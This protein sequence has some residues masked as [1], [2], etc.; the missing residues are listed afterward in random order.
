MIEQRSG[1]RRRFSEHDCK[2]GCLASGSGA[3]RELAWAHKRQSSK[4]RTRAIAAGSD[5][6]WLPLRLRLF[7]LWQTCQ[8]IFALFG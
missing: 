6:V 2:P 3:E 8:T 1:S 5:R 7:S 4:S